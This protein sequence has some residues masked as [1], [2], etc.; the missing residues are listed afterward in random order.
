MRALLTRLIPLLALA[1][2]LPAALAQPAQVAVPPTIRVIV[3]FAPG[4]GTDVLARAVANLL[5]QRLAPT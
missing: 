2:P 1:A 5:A 3:P 4:A